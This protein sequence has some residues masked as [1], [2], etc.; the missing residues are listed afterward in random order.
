MMIKLD[1]PPQT[2]DAARNW[3][4]LLEMAASL[5]RREFGEPSIWT[6]DI[7][8]ASARVIELEQA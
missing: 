2:L 6:D 4:Y 1:N 3:L 5:E 7:Q 8:A